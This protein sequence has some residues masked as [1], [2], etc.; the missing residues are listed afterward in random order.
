MGKGIKYNASYG[1]IGPN[2]L[3]GNFSSGEVSQLIRVQSSEVSFSSPPTPTPQ[4]GSFSAPTT[5]LEGPYVDLNLS[6]LSTNGENETAAGF[7]TDGSLGAFANLGQNERHLFLVKNPDSPND[8]TTTMGLGHMSLMGYEVNATINQPVQSSMTFRGF[9]ASIATGVTGYTPLINLSNGIPTEDY[10]YKLPPY[11]QGIHERTTGNI[12]NSIINRASDI[13]LTYPSGAS[14]GSNILNTSKVFIQSFRL[15]VS[16]PRSE[17]K[18]LN[19]RYPSNRT[20]NYPI[21]INASA[22][23]TLSR[24]EVEQLQSV[25]NKTGD[26]E[27][28]VR[29]CGL[30]YDENWDQSGVTSI[31]Y[32]LKGARF[33][34]QSESLSIGGEVDLTLDWQVSLGNPSSET[35]NFLISG[36]YGEL[37]YVFKDYQSGSGESSVVG[38][39]L[40]I[41]DTIYTFNKVKKD[42]GGQDFNIRLHNFPYLDS[43]A[44]NQEFIYQGNTGIIN[45]T[46]DIASG[47]THFVKDWNAAYGA[48]YLDTYKVDSYTGVM[49]PYD[50]GWPGALIPRQHNFPFLIELNG[51]NDKEITLGIEGLPSGISGWF[52]DPIFTPDPQKSYYFNTFSIKSTDQEFPIAHEYNVGIVAHTDSMRKVLPFRIRTEETYHVTLL[53]EYIEK[54]NMWVDAYDRFSYVMGSGIPDPARDDQFYHYQYLTDKASGIYTLNNEETSNKSYM[55]ADAFANK[56]IVTVRNDQPEQRIIASGDI[57]VEDYS[58]FTAF[59]VG[60]IFNER[61]DNPNSYILWAG[62]TYLNIGSGFAYGRSGDAAIFEA[63]EQHTGVTGIFDDRVH[64]HTLRYDGA[65]V[66][67]R[68]D[69]N[70]LGT[71]NMSGSIGTASGEG[72]VSIYKDGKGRFCELAISSGFMSNE[73][74]DFMEGYFKYKWH[75]KSGYVT[76]FLEHNRPNIFEYPDLDVSGQQW[77]CDFNLDGGTGIFGQSGIIGYCN[78]GGFVWPSQHPLYIL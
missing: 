56:T 70:S 37:A 15:N 22:G 44:Y 36:N 30:E 23:L 63:N 24:H 11:N 3:T 17:S 32:T 54:M 33:V 34:S 19:N 57:Y 45:V 69:G 68:I 71:W 40:H 62:D 47:M 43:G 42:I 18:K 1:F 76:G 38:Q 13:I 31:K 35:K 12:G 77:V 49:V 29:T 21:T 74:V 50:Y 75:Y 51:F 59:I 2:R 58:S 39:G 20:L 16:L 60:S 8:P 78:V 41:I 55:L 25:I 53:P 14:F 5:T 27:L 67:I 65:G 52:A 46:G 10:S 66:E 6:Y 4:L 73:E 48:G 72:G 28:E 61:N 7:V 9:N 64:L 26:I